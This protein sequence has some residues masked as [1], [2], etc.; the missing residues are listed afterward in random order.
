[1]RASQVFY[2]NVYKEIES[3]LVEILNTQ[4]DFLSTRTASSTRATGDAIQEIVS[5]NLQYLLGSLCKDYVAKF[6]RRAM[7]DLKFTDRDGLVYHVDVKTHRLGTSF[8]MPNL[9]SVKRLA[10]LYGDDKNYFVVLFVQ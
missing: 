8:N 10:D 3:K 7:A 5:E 6:P 2:T 9:T 4:P 1:M